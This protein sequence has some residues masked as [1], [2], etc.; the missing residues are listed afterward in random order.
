MS[1]DALVVGERELDH[2][3]AT[4]GGAL[5]AKAHGRLAF[6]GP[7]PARDRLVDLAK[8][9][10]VRGYTLLDRVVHGGILA[11]PVARRRVLSH[12]SSLT[13]ST[14]VVA[15]AMSASATPRSSSRPARRLW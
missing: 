12:E 9:R 10:F 4:E 5:A 2:A 13:T 14:G 6:A 7:L 1:A 3:I 15:S 8:S 11:R